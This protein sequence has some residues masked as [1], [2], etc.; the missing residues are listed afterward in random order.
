MRIALTLL[1]MVLTGCQGS[2]TSSGRGDGPAVRRPNIVIIVVDDLGWRDLG[3]YGQ[4]F[5]KTPRIDALATEG[6]VF[7]AAYA[8]C[9]VCSPTRAALM[10]GKY[11]AR[12]NITDWIPGTQ[13]PGSRMIGVN[14]LNALPLEEQ[15]LAEALKGV[16]YSTLH[17]GKWHLGGEGFLPRDQ[18]FDV[19]LMGSH[20]GHPASH[21]HPYGN[22][23][24]G[25]PAHSHAVPLA[26]VTAQ[27]GEYLADRQGEE[28]AALIRKA[29]AGRDPFFMHLSFYGVHTPLEAKQ[30]DVARYRAAKAALGEPASKAALPRPVYAA[31]VEEVDGAIG[32][33]LDALRESGVEDET[34][35]ML[36]SDNGGLTSSTDNSPLRDGKRSLWEGGIR[37]PLIIRWP[38]IAAANRRDS[39]PVITQD[40][41]AT[42]CEAAGATTVGDVRDDSRSLVRLLE[43]PGVDLDRPSLYWHFPH[44]Q[45]MEVGPRSAVRHGQWKMIES[46]EDGSV[47]LFDLAADPGEQHECSTAHAA[48][49]ASLRANLAAWRTRVG[50]R[51]PTAR[52]AEP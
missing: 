1:L 10:T 48:V 35:V 29:A 24:D 5:A 51:M 43:H 34:L 3:P 41:F 14:D 44:H 11:P 12:V 13:F 23:A 42:A 16:G 37:V 25:K 32:C 39:T 26:G 2:R 47:M 46:L 18:G 30:E 28:A 21:F 15:T 49:V 33:V 38:G 50:A 40:L 4:T 52:R 7:D 17:V 36:T 8:A 19:N 22:A 6:V 20:I 45:T 27:A 31:M 9:P